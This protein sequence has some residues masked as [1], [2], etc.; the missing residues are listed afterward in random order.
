MLQGKL[1]THL[2]D[3]LEN[4]FPPNN[5]DAHEKNWHPYDIDNNQISY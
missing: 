5:Y 3:G 1:S 4:S 2:K